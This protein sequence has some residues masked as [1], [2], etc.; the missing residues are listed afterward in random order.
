MN[1]EVREGG[2]VYVAASSGAR[3]HGRF[4]APGGERVQVDALSGLELTVTHTTTHL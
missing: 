3:T 4:T 1:G 2:L